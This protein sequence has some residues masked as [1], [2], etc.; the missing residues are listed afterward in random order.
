M[1]EEMID[2]SDLEVRGD[3]MNVNLIKPKRKWVFRILDDEGEPSI[4]IS[5][6]GEVEINPKLTLD[7]ASL[8]FWKRVQELAF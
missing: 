2:F 6:K 3:S 7:E 4:T 5:C 1:S 8:L